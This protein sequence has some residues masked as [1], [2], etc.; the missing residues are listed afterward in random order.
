MY[1]AGKDISSEGS[2]DVTDPFTN[3]VVAQVPAATQDQV[4][5]AFRLSANYNANLSRY[6][7]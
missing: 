5:E 1:I 3:D 7:R 6:E 4:A 2:I